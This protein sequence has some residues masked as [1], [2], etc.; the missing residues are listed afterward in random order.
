M[1]K[2]K[3]IILVMLAMLAVVLAQGIPSQIAAQTDCVGRLTSATTAGIWS[4]DCL[5]QN[6]ENAYARYYA[7][8]VSEQAEV[9]ITLESDTDPYLFLLDDSDE[10]I[11]EN[12]DIDLDEGD[13]N[14]RIIKTLDPGDYTIEATTYDTEAAGEYTLTVSGIDLGR[15]IDRAALVSL[16]NATDGPQLANQHRLA[17]R[18]S[19]VRLVRRDHR[20][21]RPRH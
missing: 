3:P 5:S 11:V 4:A 13:F 19:L 8:S 10:V 1:N 17:H 15:Q 16:Y 14:S 9:T 21:G 6:R 12:D 7:F 2:R 18:R 20:R